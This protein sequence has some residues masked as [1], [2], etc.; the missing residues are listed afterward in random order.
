MLWDRGLVKNREETSHMGQQDFYTQGDGSAGQVWDPWSVAVDPYASGAAWL[1]GED[2]SYRIDPVTDTSPYA[3]RHAKK[4]A[5]PKKD[6]TGSAAGADEPVENAAV[7]AKPA[8]R[9][10]RFKKNTSGVAGASG[11]AGVPIPGAVSTPLIPGSLNTA[12]TSV[13]SVAAGGAPSVSGVPDAVVR[14]AAERAR[15]NSRS[16]LHIVSDDPNEVRRYAEVQHTMES[17]RLMVQQAENPV[18]ALFGSMTAPQTAPSAAASSRTAVAAQVVPQEDETLA[19][20]PSA[21]RWRRPRPQYKQAAADPAATGSTVTGAA[22]AAVAGV[23]QGA[24]GFTAQEAPVKGV[25]TVGRQSPASAVAPSAQVQVPEEDG[26]PSARRSTGK[27][28][29]VRA[30]GTAAS[31][32]GSVGAWL[33]GRRAGTA[34]AAQGQADAAEQVPATKRRKAHKIKPEA[35]AITPEQG[36]RTALVGVT[37][38]ACVLISLV[39]LYFPAQDLYLAIRERE[40]NADELSRNL[41]RNEQMANRVQY[42]QTAEGVQDEAH[43]LFGY[44]MPGESAVDVVG[45]EVDEVDNAIPAQVKRGSGENT[46]T[47]ATDMLDRVFGATG[48]DASTATESDVAEVTEIGADEIAASSGA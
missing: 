5:K 9:G 11:D 6:A 38:L 2:G 1:V 31:A 8:A 36:W 48:V 23:G 29:V 47:W 19:G 33:G 12:R 20:K 17:Q 34:P 40:R 21:A 39:M 43:R 26:K 45:I 37:S 44:V 3:A 24:D 16:V 13:P 7:A 32:V 42:L 10:K 27:N 46:H 28:P 4:H 30:F 41:A 18:G 14:D 35:K 25:P 22:S 15:T